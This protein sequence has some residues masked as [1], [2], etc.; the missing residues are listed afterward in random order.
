MLI[1]YEISA[2]KFKPTKMFLILPEKH[3]QLYIQNTT[4]QR[5]FEPNLLATFMVTKYP[6]ATDGSFRYENK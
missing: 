1:S 2:G 4:D 6:L 3:D 5:K